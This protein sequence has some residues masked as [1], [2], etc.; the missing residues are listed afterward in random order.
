MP[1]AFLC[2]RIAAA[3]GASDRPLR[4]CL[5]TTLEEPDLVGR[6]GRG[7]LRSGPLLRTTPSSGRAAIGTAIDV[8]ASPGYR[9]WMPEVP[10]SQVPSYLGST[11]RAARRLVDEN[12][13]LRAVI[14]SNP[15]QRA[16]QTA[17]AALHLRPLSAARLTAATALGVRRPIPYRLRTGPTV[18]MR[19]RTDDL[20]SLGEVFHRQTYAI[21]DVVI[22]RLSSI[23]RPNVVDLG[24]NVGMF[25]V[26]IA[27]QLGTCDVIA[28]EADPRN[29][30]ILR[31]TMS[32]NHLISCDVVEAAA[33]TS[34]GELVFELG[35]FIRSRASSDGKGTRVSAIDIF[36]TLRGADL[37][38]IDI[39]GGEWPILTDARFASIGAS[40]I[41]MEWHETDGHPA[42]QA[43]PD[44]ESALVAAGYEI[45]ERHQT[46]PT[47]GTFWAVRA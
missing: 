42:G 7:R 30:A 37:L 17:R 10:S 29:A 34:D 8:P 41:T 12:Q 33:S 32:E 5:T 21:P 16:I 2:E 1:V 26:W 19:G 43:G 45:V 46:D 25:S 22:E 27:G 39:E 6:P 9:P 44:A 23:K 14:K 31:R 24:A 47:C 18:R 20:V 36:P 28:V 38:K 3:P 35:N 40:A 15:G 11:G 4:A 13:V